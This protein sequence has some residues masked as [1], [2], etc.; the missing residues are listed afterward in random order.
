MKYNSGT[1]RYRNIHEDKQNPHYTK[2]TPVV[3]V[4]DFGKAL[5]VHVEES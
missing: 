5:G 2:E 1:M 4:S 3:I